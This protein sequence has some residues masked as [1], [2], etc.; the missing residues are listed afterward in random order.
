MTK[1]HIRTQ[2]FQPVEVPHP[3]R[4]GQ[5][6]WVAGEVLDEFGDLSNV[7][8]GCGM[9][10]DLGYVKYKVPVSDPRFGQLF[11]CPNN[12]E[13]ARGLERDRQM[14]VHAAMRLPE[15]YQNCTLDSFCALMMARPELREGKRLAYAAVD[16]YAGAAADDFYVDFAEVALRAGLIGE[17]DWRNCLILSGD[18]GVGKTGLMA[19]IGKAVV[20]LGI[21]VLY[22]RAMSALK[23]IQDRYNPDWRDNPPDDDFGNVEAGN[24]VDQLSNVPLLL[25]DEFDLPNLKSDGDKADKM[26]HIMRMRHSRRLPTVI[27]TNLK[28]MREIGDRWG[29]PTAQVLGQMAHLIP[30]TGEPLRPVPQLLEV[31]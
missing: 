22:V 7:D 17:T 12:C 8:F 25:L 3:T 30:I 18:Y 19:S 26:Q 6:V 4:R 13:A 24:I 29:E 1:E 11:P 23:A 14:R 31:L 15:E 9:C 28:T 21:I 10:G 2:G 16:A 27:T 20:P 5:T